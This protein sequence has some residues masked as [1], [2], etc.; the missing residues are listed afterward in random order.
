MRTAAHATLNAAVSDGRTLS[1][2]LAEDLK[3]HSWERNFY[4]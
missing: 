2:N 3:K 1:R 4:R